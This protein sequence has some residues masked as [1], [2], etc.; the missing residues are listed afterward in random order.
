[1][2]VVESGIVTAPLGSGLT[3]Q[4]ASHPAK[5]TAASTINHERRFDDLRAHAVMMVVV[6]A[7]AATATTALR[8]SDW[9]PGGRNRRESGFVVAMAGS[10]EAI[11]PI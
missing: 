11:C 1:M 10:G 7:A 4:P 5:Q 9:E 3:K 8:E 6:P 2:L